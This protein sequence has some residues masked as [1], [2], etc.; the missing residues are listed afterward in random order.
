MGLF[1]DIEKSFKRLTE[2]VD[3]VSDK[4][5]KSKFKDLEDKDLDNDGDADSSDKYLHKRLG[6]VALK[7]EEESEE[8]LDEMSTSAAT[9][10]YMTPKAF[11]KAGDDTV[12]ADGWKRVKKT[13]KIFRPMENKSS[14]KKMMSEM[15]GVVDELQLHEAVNPE[16]DKAVKR[17][18][19]A[20]AKKYGYKSSDAVM[21]VFQALTRLN[22]IHNS[23]KYKAPSGFEIE[24]AVSYRQY[25]KDESASPSQKVNKSIMEVNK[26]LAEIEKIVHNNIR[27]KTETGVDS[28][29]FWKQTGN[30]INKI[31]ERIV[32]ISNRLKELS[33]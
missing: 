19:D 29:Q 12:E 15:Y 7:T 9:P 5:A 31:N 30:R 21:A 23:V 6:K 2:G 27:L 8:E 3:D 22:L 14:Y 17:F 32:R 33:K 18:I 26:M 24:E 4:E 1:K 28:S 20:L 13:N 25:K 11:G 10:G 16:L